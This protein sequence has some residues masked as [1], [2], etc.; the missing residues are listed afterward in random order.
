VK[1]TVPLADDPS[2]RCGATPEHILFK[3]KTLDWSLVV[4]TISPSNDVTHGD[5]PAVAQGQKQE[6][7]DND[8][9]FPLAILKMEH[10]VTQRVTTL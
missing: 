5:S 7:R 8:G 1:K 4:L 3:R 10:G 9:Q 2:L 6:K